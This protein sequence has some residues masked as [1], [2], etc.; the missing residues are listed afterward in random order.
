MGVKWEFMTRR[1]TNEHRREIAAGLRTQD[2]EA[3]QLIRLW[4]SFLQ[5]LEY[6]HSL[7]RSDS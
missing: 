2:H 5:R 1:H 6:L 3:M 4:E 7:L